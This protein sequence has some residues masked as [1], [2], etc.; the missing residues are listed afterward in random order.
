MRT[1]LIVGGLVLLLLGLAWPWITALGLGHLPGDVRIER[2]GLRVYFPITSSL[3]VS[4]A[5]S[6]LLSL[7]F[8]LWRR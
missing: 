1:A 2:P 8:W 5:L 7:I 6:L 3:L 4:V